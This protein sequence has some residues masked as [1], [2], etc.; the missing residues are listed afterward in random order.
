MFSQVIKQQ[1]AE[2]SLL[3]MEL[4]AYKDSEEQGL[5]VKLPCRAGDTIYDIYEFINNRCQPEIIEYKADTIGIKK[6]KSGRLYFIIDSTIFH[7]EDFGKTAFLNKD[8]VI[9]KY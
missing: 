4:Q 9:K 2:I 6:D 7:P 3:K 8:D 1:E 5:L